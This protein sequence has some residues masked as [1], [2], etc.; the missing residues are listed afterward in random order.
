MLIFVGRCEDYDEEEMPFTTPKGHPFIDAETADT[1]HGQEALKNV[2]LNQTFKLGK[3]KKP[4]FS[5]QY[6]RGL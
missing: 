3:E 5:E 4:R 1:E 2:R 6:I